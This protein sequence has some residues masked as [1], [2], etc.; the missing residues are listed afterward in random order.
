[1]RDKQKETSH[2]LDKFVFIT[3]QC[4]LFDVVFSYIYIYCSTGKKNCIYYA[5]L[6]IGQKNRS[7]SS[8]FNFT[9]LFQRL[10]SLLGCLG[11][12]P[13]TYR[14]KAEYSTI[15]LTTLQNALY[16]EFLDN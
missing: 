14:L 2:F 10:F 15:E 4:F 5:F 13:R 9:L 12:E 6:I 16:T 11:L 8:T 3:S 7:R 1:M